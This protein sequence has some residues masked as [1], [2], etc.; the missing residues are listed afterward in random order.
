M[1]FFLFSFYILRHLQNYH[2]FLVLKWS[3]ED[4][5]DLPPFYV[6]LVLSSNVAHST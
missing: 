6:F 3:I 5:L 1:L 2:F 4:L